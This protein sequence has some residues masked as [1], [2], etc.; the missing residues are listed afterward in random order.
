MFADGA[1]HL[2]FACDVSNSNEVKSL[3]DFALKHYNSAPNVV[4]NSAGIIRDSILLKMSE[5]QFDD[6]IA[7]NLKGTYLVK[8]FLLWIMKLFTA[9]RSCKESNACASKYDD[10]ILRSTLS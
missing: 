6:V 4:V 1:K 5:K 2:S 10:N 3:V 7:V 8:I 9:L